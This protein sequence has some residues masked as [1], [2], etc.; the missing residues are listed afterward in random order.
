MEKLWV[1]LRL[2]CTER[3]A[4]AIRILAYME[5]RTIMGQVRHLL[6][7]GL[8]RECERLREKKVT[9]NLIAAKKLFLKTL[10]ESE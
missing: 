5:D 10:D 4:H 8:E 7:L 3:M 6:K 2:R 1:D 9:P